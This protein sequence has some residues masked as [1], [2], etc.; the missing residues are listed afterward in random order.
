[1]DTPFAEIPELPFSLPAIPT[2]L[3]HPRPIAFMGR[4]EFPNP[5]FPIVLRTKPTQPPDAYI[6]DM[7]IP[8]TD[9][10]RAYDT[11]YPCSVEKWPSPPTARSIRRINEDPVP[12]GS[13]TPC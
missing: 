2:V 12:F 8:I 4:G 11:L 9:L 3:L 13:Q 10:A 5:E 6:A 1:M 7:P